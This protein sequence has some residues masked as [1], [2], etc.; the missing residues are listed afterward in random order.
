MAKIN[1]RRIRGSWADGYALDVHSTGSTF[2]GYDEFGHPVFDT[3]RTE[4]GELLYRLKYKGDASALSEIGE[5]AEQFIRSWGVSFS[6]IVPVPPTRTRRIQPVFQ[7]ADELASRFGV[8]AGKDMVRKLK[9]VAELKNI[10]EFEE[11][12]KVLE[13]AFRV[14][15]SYVSGAQVLLVDD[16][17]RS[18]AT[19]SAVAE[20]LTYAGAAAVYA[21]A[22]TQTRRI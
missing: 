22:L 20:A 3:M 19:M 13:N 10:H 1:P 8:S 12:R 15:A 17:M 11:R 21:F 9:N 7:I 14:E 4:V 18:G 6:V 16:L 2:L 5:S